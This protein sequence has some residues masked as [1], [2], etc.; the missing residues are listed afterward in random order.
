MAIV[1][2][3]P[4]YEF[5]FKSAGSLMYLV[6]CLLPVVLPILFWA[7]Y[8][9]YKDRHLPEPVGHLAEHRLVADGE[10]LAPAQLRDGL[11][12]SRLHGLQAVRQLREPAGNQ[13]R[14]H[15]DAGE[16]PRPDHGESAGRAAVHHRRRR[17]GAGA[18][19]WAAS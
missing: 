4:G 3:R 11:Q 12:L 13:R 19:R 14:S 5:L 2:Q 7:A 18:Y 17:R 16:R 1:A 6:H 8:H 15:R 10:L 9:Y